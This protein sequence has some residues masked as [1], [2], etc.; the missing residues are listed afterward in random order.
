MLNACGARVRDLLRVASFLICF[1]NVLLQ[2]RDTR[3]T[4]SDESESEDKGKGPAAPAPQTQKFR[5]LFLKAEVCFLSD[6]S[7]R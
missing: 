7:I 1:Q 3:G 4:E 6:P 2:R 5:D